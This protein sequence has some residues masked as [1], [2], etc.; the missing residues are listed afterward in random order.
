[1]KKKIG[2]VEIVHIKKTK[3]QK[4]NLINKLN[5]A[6]IECAWAQQKKNIRKHQKTPEIT[7]NLQKSLEL[8]RNHQKTPEIARNY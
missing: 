8:S 3:I 4:N 2:F 6:K 5:S 1:M 7:R